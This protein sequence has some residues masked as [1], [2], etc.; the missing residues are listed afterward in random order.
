MDKGSIIQ[1]I[2]ANNP[3]FGC[4]MIVDEV[5][6][7][8]CTAHSQWLGDRNEKG[9]FLNGMICGRFEA[10]QYVVVGRVAV[11]TQSTNEG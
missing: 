6:S 11:T 9:H 5:K 1:V 4:I 3:F 2:D 10:K 8:G 7:F